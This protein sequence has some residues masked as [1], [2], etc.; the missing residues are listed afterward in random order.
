MGNSLTD[1][2]LLIKLDTQQA[3]MMKELE[4][5]REDFVASETSHASKRDFDKLET[6]V[7]DL[8]KSIKDNYVTNDRFDPVRRVVYG[9]IS[10]ILTA[11]VVA[12]IGLVVAG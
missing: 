7:D 1:R 10:V 2:E 8:I 9:V 3:A 5:L 4:R 12:M 6:K 11:V